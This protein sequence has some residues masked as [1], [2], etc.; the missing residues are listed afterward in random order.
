[1]FNII[2]NKTNAK[3]VFIKLKKNDAAQLENRN[4]TIF[5]EKFPE[6]ATHDSMRVLRKYRKNYCRCKNTLSAL[7]LTKISQSQGSNCVSR[8]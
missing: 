6:I 3:N 5:I 1:M 7:Y 2:L 8:D 4:D